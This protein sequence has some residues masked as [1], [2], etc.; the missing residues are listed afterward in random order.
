MH[1]YENLIMSKLFI[2]S[3]FILTKIL[4]FGQNYMINGGFEIINPTPAAYDANGTELY[5]HSIEFALGWFNSPIIQGNGCG[6]PSSDLS[7]PDQQLY[8][9]PHEPH[10]GNGHGMFGAVA[11]GCN[12]YCYGTTDNLTA[13]EMYSISFWI[14]KPDIATSGVDAFVGLIISADIPQIWQNPFNISHEPN[15]VIDNVSHQYEKVTICYTPEVSGMHYLTFGPLLG[16]S[17]SFENIMFYIDDV[18]V[19]KIPINSPF[20]VANVSLP[21]STFCMGDDL[22][23]DG[24]LSENETG[25]TWEIYHNYQNE[26]I[27]KY[28]SGFQ[29]GEVNQLEDVLSLFSVTPGQCYKAYLILDGICPDTSYVEFCI[30]NPFF[31]FV[32]D[33]SPVCEN[34]SFELCTDGDPNWHYE[35][36]DGQNG[37]GLNCADIT[38]NSFI[39]GACTVV[40]TT[41]TGCQHF[42]STLI[43][44]HSENNQPAWM[45]GIWGSENYTTFVNQ[46][47]VAYIYSSLYNDNDYEELSYNISHNL[48]SNYDIVN[49]SA[50]PS[51][52][53]N[54]GPV[55]IE[56]QTSSS[57]PPGNYFINLQT[58]D[59]NACGSA[60]SDH[61]FEIKVICDHCAKCVYYTD[62]S[63]PTDNPL[64]SETIAGRCISAGYDQAI[65]TGSENIL[66]QAGNN[67]RLG[68]NFTAGNGFIAE[69]NTNSCIDDCETC[70]DDWNGFSYDPIQDYV[71]FDDGNPE[72]DIWQMTDVSN[73]FCAFNAN[74][75]SLDILNASGNLIH[76]SEYVT[77]NCCPF[78]S[79]GP[80]NNLAYSDIWWNGYTENIFG[81]MVHPNDGTYFYEVNLYGCGGAT[82][83]LQGFFHIGPGGI[84]PDPNDDG[85]LNDDALQRSAN[86]VDNTKNRNLNKTQK[87]EEQ[88]SLFPNPTNETLNIRGITE[89][90]SIEITDTKGKVLMN[91]IDFL[92]QIDVSGLSNGIYFLKISIA[93]RLLIK[94]FLKL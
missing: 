60:N 21:Q 35:W 50:F 68:P 44:I 85:D 87:I 23:I 1:Q 63:T 57:T 54:G 61:T 79:P 93:D 18:S 12:E 56:W 26:E 8:G 65:N 59:N 81:N 2:F 58:E 38:A 48:T 72:T 22:N 33:N 91:K 9:N 4:V 41:P 77:S 47:E 13:G 80:G 14:K 78:V 25:Y 75:Y 51:T 74:G 55:M 89:P 6:Q 90:F 49:L 71:D 39:N 92:E 3:F 64:P 10:S 94:E 62:E 53:I 34:A 31:S 43:N 16:Y 73:P 42:Q 5:G 15:V 66:F 84:I 76:S 67:I 7:H 20:P 11:N 24:S 52:D 32:Y 70:C 83:T 40:A 19:N 27:I 36:I 69:I 82:E 45:D 30:D 46:G 28:S 17:H 37:I 88:I 29:S 86:S